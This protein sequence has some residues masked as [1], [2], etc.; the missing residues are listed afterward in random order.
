MHYIRGRQWLS[1]F[2][3]AYHPWVLG[4]NPE[5]SIHDFIVTLC[6][7]FVIVLRK[8]TKINQNFIAAL[9][10]TSQDDM[11]KSLLYIFD[12]QIL[13]ILFVLKLFL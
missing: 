11:V 7:I 8:R 2:A 13:R 5:H 3:C 4:S 1:G 10:K 12:A 9:P 6:T